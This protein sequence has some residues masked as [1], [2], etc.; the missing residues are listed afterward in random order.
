LAGARL[1]YNLTSP[2]HVLDQARFVNEFLRDLRLSALF[3]TRLPL[4]PLA[5]DE[6]VPLSTAMRAFPLVG[7]LI[8]LAGGLALILAERLEWPPLAAGLFAVAVLVL[9]T[10][11]LHE[12]GLADCADS[13]GAFADKEKKLSILKDS[14]LGSFGVLALIFSVGLRATLLAAVTGVEGCWM[15]IGAGAI[16]RAAVPLIMLS[17]KPAREDGLGASAG[18][19]DVTTALWA[20]GISLLIAFVALGGAA[21]AAI[22]YAALAAGLMLLWA[23]RQIGGYTG[24]VLGACIQLCEIAVLI[25]GLS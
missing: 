20:S 10:G 24:D 11:G 4:R 2:V 19:P 22:A 14:R 3:L 18:T 15:L 16:S 13:F 6:L 9:L 8:G 25:A 21:L 12:D 23:K 7:A 5:Q 1:S 17:A